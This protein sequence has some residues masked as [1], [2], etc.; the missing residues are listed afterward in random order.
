MV[1]KVCNK[2]KKEKKISEFY[3]DKN[4]NKIRYRCKLCDNKYHKEY[5]LRTN[6]KYINSVKGKNVRNKYMKSIKGREAR[7]RASKKAYKKHFKKWMCRL[8]TRYY[9]KIGK[10]IKP[11]MCEM[12][13]PHPEIPCYGR[14]EAHHSDYSKPLLVKWLCSK[15]HHE[16]EKQL[17]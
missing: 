12:Y 10:L 4:S 13:S 3:F 1:F 6:N 8:K 11:V 7:N 16:L 5:E 14:I 15:H 9:V 2:C 17:K